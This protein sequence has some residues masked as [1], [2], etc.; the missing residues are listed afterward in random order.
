M[1]VCDPRIFRALGVPKG[2]DAIACRPHSDAPVEPG[3]D[4]DSVYGRESCESGSGLEYWN[5][6]EWA[7]WSE[8]RYR[9][10]IATFFEEPDG[11]H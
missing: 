10:V 8:R 3:P 1:L 4:P 5:D 2:L 7:R 9:R 11:C 6:A